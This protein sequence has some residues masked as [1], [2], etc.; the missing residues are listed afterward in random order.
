MD[1]KRK[2]GL[3]LVSRWCSEQCE[4]S[5]QIYSVTAT[6]TDG[7]YWGLATVLE[8]PRDISEGGVDMEN[9]H[10][11]D[12]RDSYL[13]TSR[14]LIVVLGC[15]WLSRALWQGRCAL[16]SFKR[17]S[18]RGADKSWRKRCLGQRSDL[19]DA[20]HNHMAWP[21]LVRSLRVT[22]CSIIHCVI[23]DLW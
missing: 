22:L 15:L 11:R 5:R 19:R 23:S 18:R 10:E 8:Y 7:V 12:V 16:G 2:I 20:K 13:V 9:R 3:S 17:V 4:C 14:L 21:A 1:C 6:L